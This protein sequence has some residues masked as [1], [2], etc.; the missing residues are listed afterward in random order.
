MKRRGVSENSINDHSDVVVPVDSDDR[1]GGGEDDMARAAHEKTGGGSTDGSLSPLRTPWWCSESVYKPQY[2]TR[3]IERGKNEHVRGFSMWNQAPYMVNSKDKCGR[4]AFHAAMLHCNAKALAYLMTVGHE[5]ANGG[6]P[7]STKE[8]PYFESPHEQVHLG[9]GNHDGDVD[10]DFIDPAESPEESLF[11][12]PGIPFHGMSAVHLGLTTLPALES[13]LLYAVLFA[14]R[15]PAAQQSDT[16][17]T[18]TEE[19]WNTMADLYSNNPQIYQPRLLA[20]VVEKG[21]GVLRGLENRINAH[22]LQHLNIDAL[23]YEGERQSFVVVR[24]EAALLL[25]REWCNLCLL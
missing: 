15:L 21:R 24:T 19:E 9:A 3:S 12:H 11:L 10:L 18:F 1:G 8:E 17:S 23:D 22:T 4:T 16:I 5:S 20:A 2:L 14:H 7:G 13:A 6:V 25:T